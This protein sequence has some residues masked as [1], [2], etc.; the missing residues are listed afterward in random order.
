MKITGKGGGYPFIIIIIDFALLTSTTRQLTDRKI[1]ELL[2]HISS[3]NFHKRI[4]LTIAK[5]N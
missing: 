4:I 3:F 2:L 1:P 5:Y